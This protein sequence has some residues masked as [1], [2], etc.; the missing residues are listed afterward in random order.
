MA[1]TGCSPPIAARRGGQS[2]LL[3][4]A[5]VEQP[6]GEALSNADSPVGPGIA[7]VIATTSRRLAAYSITRLE[8]I[9]VHPG[10]TDFVA[11]PVRGSMTPHECICSAASFSAAHTPCLSG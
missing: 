7:A 8:K 2:V 3:G 5:D 4:D 11:S 1:T 10:D 6:V 9:E